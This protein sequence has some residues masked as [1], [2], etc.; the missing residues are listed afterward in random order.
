MN[1]F[2]TVAVSR[3]GSSVYELSDFIK[4]T[5]TPYVQR[6]GG[7]SSVSA[8]G[9]VEQLVQVQLNQEKVDA[10]NEKLMELIDSSA[11]SGARPAGGCRGQDQGRPRR[12]R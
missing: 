11:G 8:S 9:L 6:K 1:A 5:M 2:M 7:V 10:I 3:E 12:I 4:N